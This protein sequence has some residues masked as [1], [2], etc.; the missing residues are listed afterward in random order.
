MCV[1]TQTLE[2]ESW[3]RTSAV[4]EKDGL[5]E[6][7][8]QQLPKLAALQ[9]RRREADDSKSSLQENV[10][11]AVLKDKLQPAKTERGELV[12]GLEGGGDLDE[13]RHASSAGSSSAS[14]EGRSFLVAT[15]LVRAN[16]AHT[17]GAVMENSTKKKFH[18]ETAS[19]VLTL[20]MNMAAV[21]K[22]GSAKRAVFNIKLA[23][24]L[25][26][27]SG[28]KES[29]F[30]ITRVSAG[31]VVV[32]VDIRRNPDEGGYDPF[33]I[34][35]EM[36]RQARD[37]KSVLRSGALTGKL[38]SFQLSSEL[39]AGSAECSNPPTFSKA[40]LSYSSA[41][42]T[43]C[44]THASSRAG[45]GDVSPQ[46]APDEMQVKEK[47]TMLELELA[48]KE[49]ELSKEITQGQYAVEEALSALQQRLE[50]K[51][52]QLIWRQMQAHE[53]AVKSLL[54]RLREDD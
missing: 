20:D 15:N 47:V 21:G 40:D 51:Y 18:P 31:R 41:E 33:A 23:E 10:E 44:I 4:K 36:E 14:I 32:E 42:S 28:I 16:M 37:P 2:R 11:Y 34:S 43:T 53:Q 26:K 19:T 52:A 29:S 54:A 13:I 49:A 30:K 6:V 45:S 9:A 3:G 17:V 5:W 38:A 39:P 22:E 25:A 1:R 7:H 12:N 24:D 27:A 8:E 48:A 46:A 35:R 50:A